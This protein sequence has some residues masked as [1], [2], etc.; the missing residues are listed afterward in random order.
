MANIYQV[1]GFTWPGVSPIGDISIFLSRY[2]TTQS[3]GGSSIKALGRFGGNALELSGGSFEQQCFPIALPVLVTPG[4]IRF[5]VAIQ[6]TNWLT[7]GGLIGLTDVGSV[8]P[9]NANVYSVVGLNG[10]K[11]CIFGPPF[12]TFTTILATGTT[13]LLNN[14]YY[15]I[16]ME[17]TIAGAGAGSCKVYLDG[18][19]E[20]NTGPIN[21]LNALSGSVSSFLLCSPASGLFTRFCDMYLSDT[22]LGP[23]RV[24]TSFPT[25]DGFLDQWTPSTG[26]THYNLV[27][28]APPDGDGTYVGSSTPGQID[29]YSFG[30]LSY[31]PATIAAVQISLY[32]RKDDLAAR[33]VATEYRGG[34]SNFSGAT[35]P[36]LTTTYQ[37]YPQI[38]TTDPATGIGWTVTGVNAGQYGVKLIS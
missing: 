24:T 13:V 4:T 1:E 9:A 26:T 12:S 5:G 33:T 18:N 6:S 34:G 29:L 25:A 11:L 35:L 36:A 2:N 7:N 27:N 16:E 30:A 38:Y 23:Q 8:L 28:E 19:L 10:G 14:S 21:T 22:L 32:A 3:S 20:V 37:D 31:N 17:L 15:Y